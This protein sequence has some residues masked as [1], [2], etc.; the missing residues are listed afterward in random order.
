MEVDTPKRK[1]VRKHYSDTLTWKSS[2]QF[3]LSLSSHLTLELLRCL[4]NSDLDA[5]TEY[6]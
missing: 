2:L 3:I 5:W 1:L 6:L 4:L